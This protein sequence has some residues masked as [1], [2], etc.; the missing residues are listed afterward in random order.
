MKIGVPK[1]IKIRER[2]VALTPAG[3]AAL[4]AD[5]HTVFLEKMR[6]LG[7]GFPTKAI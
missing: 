3:V 1:E 7:R 5:G 4:V 2:R 6:G